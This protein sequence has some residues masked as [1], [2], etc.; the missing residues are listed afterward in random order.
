MPE[1]DFDPIKLFQSLIEKFK[2]RPSQRPGFALGKFL[3]W[4][5]TLDYDQRVEH[6]VDLGKLCIS[7]NPAA[8]AH[9]RKLL[10]ELEQG[11]FYERQLALMSCATSKDSERI[12][13]FMKDSSAHLRQLAQNLATLHCSDEILHTLLLGLKLKERRRILKK[14]RRAGRLALI[15]S[16]LQ[17]L[18]QEDSDEFHRLFYFGSAA[19][20]EQS[21]GLVADRLDSYDTERLAYLHPDLCLTYLRNYAQSCSK[22]DPHLLYLLRGAASHWLPELRPEATLKLLE[23][24]LELYSA[25]NL[26][27]Q[28]LLQLRPAECVEIFSRQPDY[29]GANLSPVLHKLPDE[30]LLKAVTHKQFADS[31]IGSWNRISVDMREQIFDLCKDGWRDLDG[32][33]SPYVLEKLR[34][35]KRENEAQKHVVLPNLATKLAQRLSYARLLEWDSV[36][37]NLKDSLNNPDPVT[38]SAGFFH[39]VYA[40]RFN[41]SSLPEILEL[42]H[43]RKNEPDPVR[44][45]YLCALSMLPPSI[46]AKEYLPA[47]L[48]LIDDALQAQDLSFASS[49]NIGRLLLR[50]L[51]FHKDWAV[52]QLCRIMKDRGPYLSTAHSCRLLDADVEYLS[53]KL[54]TTIEYWEE[55]ERES[56]ICQLS[57]WLGKRLPSSQP[58][59]AALANVARMSKQNYNSDAAISVLYKWQ[60]KAFDSLVLELLEQDHSWALKPMIYQHLSYKR[61]SKLTPYLG[62]NPLPGRFATGK[63]R[64]VPDFTEGFHRWTRK[65]TELY[66]HELCL[67]AEKASSNFFDKH[68]GIYRL[69]CLPEPNTE[70][71][72]RLASL[73]NADVAVR[74][75]AIRQMAETDNGAGLSILLSCLN[76]ERARQAIYAL[77]NAV[78]SMEAHIALDMLRKVPLTKITVFK[79]VVR[80]AGDTK[81][82]EAFA[83]LAE[84]ESE[85]LHRDVR[86]AL[87]RALWNYPEREE[88]WAILRK[89]VTSG[90]PVFAD[91]AIRIP[92]TS[93]SSKARAQLLLLYNDALRSG[94]ASGRVKTLNQIACGTILDTGEVLVDSIE[95]S[96]G[97][98]AA[99]ECSAAG[100]TVAALY[101]GR[102]P[103]VLVKFLQSISTSPRNLRSY[104]QQL[105]PFFSRQPERYTDDVRMLCKLIE[106]LPKATEFF[107]S[108]ALGVLPAQEYFDLLKKL[109]TKKQLHSGVMQTA[110]NSLGH[111]PRGSMKDDL[112][113][114]EERMRTEKSENLRRLGLALLCGLSNSAGG[115]TDERLQILRGYR[116]D[117]SLMVSSA[118]TF[119]FPPSEYS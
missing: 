16:L 53:E 73:S 54:K 9:A 19:F 12:V 78:M 63:T 55:K 17:V 69:C 107:V 61:Q 79:E 8:V 98:A 118:A 37:Q 60:R 62:Q 105:L 117:P 88:T 7:D 90:D 38:R 40:I 106:S 89:T 72:E 116:T 50:L 95:Q 114:T 6:V 76:D 48:A 32:A 82:K 18:K 28:R 34:R 15:D 104:L 24:M 2:P 26:P 22:D 94:D 84:L 29:G 109:D 47:V 65:Q 59:L 56:E 49:S 74:D 51:P 83:W 75:L 71:L 31:I 5:E 45:Q 110:C 91:T 44:E 52:A 112:E 113:A 1:E 58:L 108:L 81:C 111:V 93:L 96:L 35:T 42:L 77:R 57:R 87:L 99:N 86:V 27:Y 100:L 70:V 36:K 85:Q 11:S 67:L 13:R 10:S 21:I 33:I 39:L 64:T 4:M 43:Q 101:A 92:A 66:S 23:S 41:R 25:S 102:N 115:W 20:V 80:L 3:D 119:I 30:M 14:L 46:F 97:A 68:F 103:Q